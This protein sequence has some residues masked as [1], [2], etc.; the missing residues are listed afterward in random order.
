MIS[1]ARLPRYTPRLHLPVLVHLFNYLLH[2]S[3]STL[4]FTMSSSPPRKSRKL[5]SVCVVP[6]GSALA[7]APEEEDRR[8]VCFTDEKELAEIFGPDMFLLPPIYHDPAMQ[9]RKLEAVDD[10]IWDH[11]RVFGHLR[12]LD[13]IR[14]A[15]LNDLLRHGNTK[16]GLASACEK[17]TGAVTK[18]LDGLDERVKVCGVG[19]VRARKA[20]RLTLKKRRGALQYGKK[21]KEFAEMPTRENLEAARDA[22]GMVYFIRKIDLH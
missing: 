17:M 11:D 7:T 15:F 2:H 18:W 20:A 5:Q 6:D 3:S 16:S 19:N 22:L 12:K 10:A 14:E 8:G 9:V 4:D 21:L 1:C 13:E